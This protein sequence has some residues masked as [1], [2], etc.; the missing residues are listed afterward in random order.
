M[1]RSDFPE[2]WDDLSDT[3]TARDRVAGT[4]DVIGR[5]H[6]CETLG[7]LDGPGLRYVLFLQ[8]CPFRCSYC[9][10]PDTWAPHGGREVSAAEQF[11]EMIRYKNYLSGGVTVSGGEPLLQA[12]FVRAL[13]SKCRAAG[14]HTAIDTSGGLPI[15]GRESA[16]HEADLILLDIKSFDRKKA[17]EMCALDT[18]H[19]WGLLDFCEKQ[20]I[21]V[22]I[23]HVLLPGATVF[24]KKEDG[25][26]ITDRESFLAYN[27]GLVAG[28]CR[29]K[30]YSCVS[31]IELLPFHKM[32]EHKWA[33]LGFPYSLG[34]AEEPGEQIVRWC[35]E[36]L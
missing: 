23:R 2:A 1:P 22:W 6:S 16:I 8:G 27:E 34:E 36:L 5:I 3:G 31:K 29:L 26:G 4:D 11:S 12:E 33:E 18:D 14:I 30:G 17:L 10:N 9:H 24:D 15:E 13:L 19:A 25:T 35:T 28:I 32:G 21:P 7:A 20:G